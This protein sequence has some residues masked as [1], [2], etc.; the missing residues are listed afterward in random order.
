MNKDLYYYAEEYRYAVDEQDAQEAW[1]KLEAFVDGLIASAHPAKGY[2]KPMKERLADKYRINYE[3]GCWEWTGAKLGDGT[4]GTLGIV[5][6]DG[7]YSTALAHRISYEYYKG[8][9]PE[10]YVI[11]HSCDN[12]GCI[13]PDHLTAG[14]FC[15]PSP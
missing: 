15:R 6:P 10:G 4:Y 9:I 14:T 7:R 1:E 12:P 5:K 11:M 8:A 13:N 2:R 3:T